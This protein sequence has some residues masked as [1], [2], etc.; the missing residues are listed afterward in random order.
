MKPV[1]LRE[2]FDCHK[3]WGNVQDRVLKEDIFLTMCYVD[4]GKEYISITDESTS[5]VVYLRP[6]L[7][8][9][10][11]LERRLSR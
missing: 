9:T 7:I 6:L 2:R 11:V 4:T 5:Y 3:Y 1:Y 8:L 10:E